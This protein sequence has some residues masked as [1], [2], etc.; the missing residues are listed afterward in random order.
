MFPDAV[1]H[2]IMM[3]EA[4]KDFIRKL[5][6]KDPLKRLGNKGPEEIMQHSWFDDMDFN[7]LIKKQLKAPYVPEVQSED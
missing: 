3:S 7:K 6:D 2:K 4:M 5:L 1:K